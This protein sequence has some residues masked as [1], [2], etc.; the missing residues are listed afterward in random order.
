MCSARWVPV[1]SFP[2][3]LRPGL[4]ASGMQPKLAVEVEKAFERPKDFVARVKRAGKW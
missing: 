1:K 4:P 3:G 2:P